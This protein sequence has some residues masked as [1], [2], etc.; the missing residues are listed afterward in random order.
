MVVDL[1]GEKGKGWKGVDFDGVLAV[2]ERMVFE[3][4]WS[5]A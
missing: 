3:T 2:V 5:R 4:Y 1:H